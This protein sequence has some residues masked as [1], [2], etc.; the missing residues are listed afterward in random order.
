[1]RARPF[2]LW[3]PAAA[4]AALILLFST[5]AASADQTGDLLRRFLRGLTDEQFS[6]AHFAIRKTAHL[7]EY[8]ILGLLNYRAVRGGREGWQWRWAAFAVAVAVGVAALDEGIQSFVPSRTAS[9]WD[10]LV[11]TIG[12]ASAQFLWRLRYPVIR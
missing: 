5:S 10:V 3:L 9:A 6:F 11:D 2:R 12:A 7:V 8:A 4:W 1:M